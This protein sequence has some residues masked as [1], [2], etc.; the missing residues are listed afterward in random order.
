M[1]GEMEALAIAAEARGVATRPGDG[2]GGA[3]SAMA[4]RLPP[5]S[6]TAAKSGTTKCAPA[7]TKSSAGKA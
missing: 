3:C 4:I 6:L 1:A 7:A 5:T 2:T